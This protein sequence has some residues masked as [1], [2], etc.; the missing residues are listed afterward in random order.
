[1]AVP[2]AARDSHSLEV[3]WLQF[4][5][6]MFSAVCV[7]A[8]FAMM[9]VLWCAPLS[10]RLQTH[11]FVACQLLG[12]WS[13]LDVFV[14]SIVACVF[15]I[16]QFVLFIVGDKCDVINKGLA[17]SPIVNDVPGVKTCVNVETELKA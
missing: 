7:V 1:M 16:Q 12:A 5:F 2:S 4:F 8:Y 6:L 9:I 14:V 11:F 13:G 17:M 3:M 10:P 15:Q